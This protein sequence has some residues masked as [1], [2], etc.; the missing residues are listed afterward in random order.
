LRNA[1]RNKKTRN[2]IKP[3]KHTN[4]IKSIKKKDRMLIK[5]TSSKV[6][7]RKKVKLMR[8]SSTK[9]LIMGLTAWVKGKAEME[10]TRNSKKVGKERSLI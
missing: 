6:R 2:S 8:K 5:L 1:N 7:S 4:R 10:V 3:L 9:S